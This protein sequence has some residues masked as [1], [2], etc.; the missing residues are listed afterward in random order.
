MSRLYRLP[1]SKHFSV[2]RT[3]KLFVLDNLEAA[4]IIAKQITILCI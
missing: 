4:I 3:E 1:I 2:I